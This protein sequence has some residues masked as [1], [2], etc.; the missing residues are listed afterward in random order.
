MFS[1]ELLSEI[2]YINCQVI[3][4]FASKRNQLY[5]LSFTNDAGVEKQM[6]Y[7]LHNYRTR[8]AKETEMLFIL[9][10]GIAPV[11]K[12]EKVIGSGILME[13]VNGPT[14]LDYFAWQEQIHLQYKEPFINHSTGALKMLADWMAAFYKTNEIIT[15]KKVILGNANIRNFIIR[16]ELYGVDFEDCREGKRE[17]DVGLICAFMLTYTPPYTLWKKVFVKEMMDLFICRLGA[18]R[19]K[20][21]ECFFNELERINKRRG[22]RLRNGWIDDVIQTI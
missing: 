18:D 13:Y 14:L 20:S 2:G 9:K 16:Q 19:S 12:V 10:N 5:L 6:V 7:K 11:P 15:G 1:K 17:E 4:R 8:M 3:G 21:I 22:L